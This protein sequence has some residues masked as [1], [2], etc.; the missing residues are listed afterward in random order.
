MT[1]VHI[2][3]DSPTTPTFTVVVDVSTFTSAFDF[4]HAVN[5]AVIV[6]ANKIDNIFLFFKVL[7]LFFV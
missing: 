1:G 2:S 3:F 6:N 4:P 7:L 5:V